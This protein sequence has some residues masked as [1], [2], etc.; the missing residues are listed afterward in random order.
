MT[1]P[2]RPPRGVRGV[3]SKLHDDQRPRLAIVY[4][5]PSHPQPVIEPVESTARHSAWGDR[6]VAWGWSRDRGVVIDAEQGHSGQSLV[7]RWGCQRV[8]AEVSL[9]HIGLSRGRE[10][11]RLARSHKDW[12]QGLERCAIF[13]TLLADAE[14]LYDPTDDN[15]R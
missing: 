14:G 6:A 7:T 4:V 5:R 2:A 11:R 13:R 1:A 12:Q 15:D 9:D 3:A 10:M 8:W